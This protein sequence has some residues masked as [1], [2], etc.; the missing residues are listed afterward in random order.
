[1][2]QEV[3]VKYAVVLGALLLIALPV[4][5]PQTPTPELQALVDTERAFARRATVKGL[6]DSFLEYFAEDSIALVPGAEPAPARLR[7]LPAQPFSDLE[8]TWEPRLG[9][10]ALSND[11]G[12]LTGPS[13]IIDHTAAQPVPRF[14][15]YLSIWRRQPDGRWRVYIDIGVNVPEL[16]TFEPGFTRMPFRNRYTGQ[17]GKSAATGTLAQADQSLND[18]ISDAGAARAYAERMIGASRLHRP[19]L[20]PAVGPDAIAAWATANAASMSAASTAAEAAASGDLGYSYGT[21]TVTTPV[22]QKGAYVRVWTRDISGAW[23]VVADVA[24]PSR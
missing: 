6:R 13:T 3:R 14:G 18:R 10:I 16:P 21:Y 2:D 5:L 17:D 11:I 12:W 15:N 24:Q 23:F 8:I 4:R 19:G 7:A 22:S 20:R 1:L 9:D